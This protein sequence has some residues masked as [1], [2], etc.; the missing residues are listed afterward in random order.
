MVDRG[1]DQDRRPR[2]RK[3]QPPSIDVNWQFEADTDGT[4]IAT[5][6]AFLG[7]DWPGGIPAQVQ[8]YVY[9]NRQDEPV[10]VAGRFATKP[11]TGF[12]PGEKVL[13]EVVA[14]GLRAGKTMD[15]PKAPERVL[16][17]AVT[18]PRVNP[19]GTAFVVT[20]MATFGDGWFAGAILPE[21]EFRRDGRKIGSARSKGRQATLTRYDF[22]PGTYLV[23]AV[24]E[25]SRAS[26]S[27]TIGELPKPNPLEGR[28]LGAKSAAEIARYRLAEA[29]ADHDRKELERPPDP[30]K[31]E[32]DRLQMAMAQAKVQKELKELSVEKPKRVTELKVSAVGADGMYDLVVTALAKDPDTGVSSGVDGVK[33][34]VCDTSGGM[35]LFGETSGSGVVRIIFPQFSVREKTIRVEALGTGI[36]KR[37]KIFGPKRAL[38]P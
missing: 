36:V 9:G 32:L 27:L 19:A 33:V 6:R 35:P 2:Q 38:N 13:V 34:M 12:V 8:F 26:Q 28:E 3:P 23:E 25:E 5:L 11:V 10:P 24:A 14:G 31:Q 18:E 29:K 7:G 4:W 30:V 16:R 17:L 37:T 22:R 15:I 1:R 21:V 20:F